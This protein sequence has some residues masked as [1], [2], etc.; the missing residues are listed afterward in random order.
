MRAEED[1]KAGAVGGGDVGVASKAGRDSGREMWSGTVRTEARGT[2]LRS[3]EMSVH[4]V[5]DCGQDGPGA[6]APAAA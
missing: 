5:G 6:P 2:S 3:T 4:H 1:E